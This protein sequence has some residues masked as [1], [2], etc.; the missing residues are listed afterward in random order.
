MT[1]ARPAAI[2][3]AATPADIPGVRQL[4]DSYIAE[5]KLLPRTDAELRSLMPHAFAASAS[6]RIV[7]FAALEIYSAKIAE[8]QC[9][10]VAAEYQGQGVGKQLVQSCVE[11]ARQQR[12]REVMVITSSDS[13][14]Q[15]CGFEFA[16]PEQR[17]AMFVQTRAD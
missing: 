12:V 9:L 15:A 7:G 8:I 3:R 4:I 2:I 5:R 6:G 1:T 14:L 13:F 16:L 17:K 11:R 10:A